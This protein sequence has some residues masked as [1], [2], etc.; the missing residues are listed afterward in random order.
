MLVMSNLLI[1]FILEEMVGDAASET[2]D[3]DEPEPDDLAAARKP[4][5]ADR[6][7]GA[8]QAASLAPLV[9]NPPPLHFITPSAESEAASLAPLV[10]NPAVVADAATM[11]P[12]LQ[13]VG[14]APATEPHAELPTVEPLLAVQSGVEPA[15]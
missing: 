12:A 5:G 15:I 7:D 11:A 6:T 4:R 1:A 8:P 13:L 3:D 14:S 2:A 9:A 10:A